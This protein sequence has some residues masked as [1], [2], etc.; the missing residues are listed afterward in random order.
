MA[1]TINGFAYRN[2]AEA[3]LAR[4]GIDPAG[5]KPAAQTPSAGA[6]ALATSQPATQT[7]EPARMGRGSIV[8][9]LA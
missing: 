1:Q 8:N 9:L 5:V 6:Q 3:A 7:A 4:R 2:P